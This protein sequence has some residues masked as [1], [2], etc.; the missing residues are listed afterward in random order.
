MPI[1]NNR[2]KIFITARKVTQRFRPFTVKI[3]AQKTWYKVASV[4]VWLRVCMGM[5]SETVFSFA[6]S[7]G[8]LR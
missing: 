3:V 1:G 7:N 8:A 5:G 2:E 6:I 4:L